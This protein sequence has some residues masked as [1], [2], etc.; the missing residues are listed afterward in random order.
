MKRFVIAIAIFLM[1]CFLAGCAEN[2]NIASEP[3]DV[4]S[5]EKEPSDSASVEE[6]VIVEDDADPLFSESDEEVRDYLS[7]FENRMGSSEDVFY[8]TYPVTEDTSLW[9]R[10]VERS[11]SGE[12]AEITI[13]QIT[14][15]GDMIYTYLFYNG[16]SYYIGVDVSRDKFKGDVDGFYTGRGWY[17]QMDI[18][19]VE[20]E[21]YNRFGGK[22]ERV[23]AYLTQLDYSAIKMEEGQVYNLPIEYGVCSFIR[24]KTE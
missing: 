14:I 17:L 21:E 10:F 9:D 18:T 6:A 4:S 7:M 11:S 23:V 5:G 16:E 12:K 1:L 20:D 19:D 22:Y 15:E 2:V 24:Q 3:E 13:G 8:V